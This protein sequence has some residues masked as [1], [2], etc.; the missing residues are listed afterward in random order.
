MT[1]MNIR[2][3]KESDFLALCEIFLRAVQETARRDY[4]ASQVAAW[5]QID[6]ATWRQKL[7]V[8]EVQVAVVDEQP[9]GFISVA[10]N[11]I[12]LLF[13]APEFNGQGIAHHLLKPWIARGDVLTVDASITAKPFFERQGFLVVAWQN[14]ECRGEWFVNYRMQYQHAS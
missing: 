11:Y 5:A 9:V 6:E 3:Y 2:E 7:A 8:S 12:D 10:G 14:V 1:A 4:S 13:V